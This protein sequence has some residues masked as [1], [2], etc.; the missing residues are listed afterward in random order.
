MESAELI[1]Q[2]MHDNYDDEEPVTVVF[3]RRIKPGREP[4]F[5]N[6]LRGIIQ[7]ASAFP[8]YL[9]QNVIRPIDQNQPEYVMILRF[10]SYANL[11]RWEESPIRQR[12][13]KLANKIAD[14]DTKI[15]KTPGLEFWFTP[16][17]RTAPAAPPR[18]K[19]VIV[20]TVVIFSLSILL[21]PA[22][23]SLL[24]SLPPL[25]RQL[26]TIGIQV[27]LI[28]Y[29]IMPFLTRLLSRWLFTKFRE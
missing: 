8:G 10:D 27:S 7:E 23:A 20:L 17:K 6:W 22:L 11:R 2:E 9:G 19:M 28:T 4:D 29:F 16:P 21:S 14:S 5:E 12:W 13:L 18:Y 24:R 26:L 1:R 15:Q 3:S 25:L